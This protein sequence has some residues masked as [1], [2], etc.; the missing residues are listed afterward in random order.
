MDQ[1][2]SQ[3][4][5]S[6]CS[7]IIAGDKTSYRFTEKLLDLLQVQIDLLTPAVYDN[8]H[9][10]ARITKAIEDFECALR[11]ANSGNVER[12]DQ[13]DLVRLVQSR[14][15]NRIKRVLWIENNE[16]VR[17]AQ[18]LQHFEDVFGFD[19]VSGIDFFG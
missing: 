1:G 9:F 8:A 2:L 14:Q 13:N 5:R 6:H 11:A 3:V 10:L 19:F 4:Y 16:L 18:A 12:Q 7:L 15:R 17:L